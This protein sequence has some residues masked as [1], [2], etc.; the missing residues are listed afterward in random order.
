MIPDN[1]ALCHIVIFHGDHLAL[2]KHIWL[3]VFEH[4]VLSAL[5]IHLEQVNL[6][7]IVLAR[8]RRAC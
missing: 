5:D 6:I 3:A 2:T 8:E 4:R 1:R 7:E